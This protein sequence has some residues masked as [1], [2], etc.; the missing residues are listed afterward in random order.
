M[1]F[2]PEAEY[3]VIRDGVSQKLDI[4]VLNQ[5]IKVWR[6]SSQTEAPT[7]FSQIGDSIEYKN[8]G[9]N[10]MVDLVY[11]NTNYPDSIK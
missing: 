7:S 2:T 6:N 8:E 4:P 11:V 10:E 3:E 1:D 9:Q 5:S